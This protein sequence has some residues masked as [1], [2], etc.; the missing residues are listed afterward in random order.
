MP[1]TFGTVQLV[2]SIAPA[3]A[4]GHPAQAAGVRPPPPDPRDLSPV[5]RQ[6]HDRAARV[7]AH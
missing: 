3:P 1:V 2:P 6:L 7:R 4:V 5:L